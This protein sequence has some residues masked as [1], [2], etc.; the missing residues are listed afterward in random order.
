MSFNFFKQFKLKSPSELVKVTREALLA[1]DTKTVAE[2]RLLE[3]ALE[4]VDKNLV[5]MKHMLLGEGDAEPNPE[6]VSLLTVEA[7]K[8]DFLE[9]LVQ[10]LPS[11]GWDA[12]KDSVNIWCTLLRQNVGGR[13]SGLEF[14]EKHTELLDFLVSCYET[15]EIALNCGNMLRECARYPS[16]AKYMLESASFE[17]FFKYVELPNFDIA[18]DAFS[19]FK[20]LLTRHEA[21]VCEY[22]T[23]H[24]VQ[25][26]RLYDRLLGSNNYVTRRQSLKLLGEFLLERA[27]APIMMQ[28]ISEV[29]NLRIMMTLIKDPSKNIQSSAF[30][31]FKVF[32]ANPNKTPAIVNILYKNRDKLLRFI[33]NFHLDKE[34]EQF[35]EEKELLIKEIESLQ[36][37]G[38]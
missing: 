12:R 31:V 9:L 18:S 29:H 8:D 20:E 10:K 26:F 6:Q 1:L 38:H 25:F 19:T 24:Y 15:K 23:T 22:L 36:P 2:V 5:A 37:L 11:L 21:I 27:N 14:I 17:L 30:H 33:D 16:L 28:Y 7:C 35:E 3:K 13:Q 34:D 4:E 32:V